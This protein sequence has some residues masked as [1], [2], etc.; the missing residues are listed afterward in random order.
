MEKELLI[1][2]DEIK[3]KVRELARELDRKYVDKDPLF[4]GVLKGSFIF[5]SDLIRSM[6]A[7]VEI[8][9][10]DVECYSDMEAGDPELIMEGTSSFEDRDVVVVEDIVDTGRTLEFLK[11]FFSSKDVASLEFC[12]LLKKPE[13][14]EF[15][16]D[17]DYVGFDIPDYFVVGYGLDVNG[18]FRGLNGIYYVVDDE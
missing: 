18:K 5:L 3:E 12:T 9:F 4:V 14:H 8:D 2:E 6:D 10:V 7:D 1:D 11:S 13:G 17:P 15:D 16:V